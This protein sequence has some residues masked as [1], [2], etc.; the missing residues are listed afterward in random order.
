M[1]SSSRTPEGDPNRCPVCGHAV[2]IDPSRP[3]GDAPCPD[4]G[5]LIWFG[6][7]PPPAD[8]SERPL[9]E[10][11]VAEIRAK[12]V[13]FVAEADQAIARSRDFL[14]KLSGVD[15]DRPAG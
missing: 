3:P 1:T 6:P 5:T 13:R 11:T 4:C 2:K 14:A 12:A 15:A 7:K 9:S 10:M 8:R